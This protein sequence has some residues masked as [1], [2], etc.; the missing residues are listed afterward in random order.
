MSSMH[1]LESLSLADV[2]SVR[3]LLKGHSVIDWQRLAFRTHEEVE[4]FLRVNEMDLQRPA[5]REHLERVRTEAVDYLTRYLEYRIPAD[6]AEELPVEQLFLLASTRERHA[7]YACVVLKVMHVIH[8]L[9]GRDTLF[10]LPISDDQVFGLVENKVMQMVEEIRAAG[11]PIVEF[12][13]S[14]KEWDSIVTKLLAKRESI[15]ARVYD[16]LRFRL[17]V[18]HKNDVLPL[19]QTLLHRFVPF[20]YVIPGQTV[21]SLLS[22]PQV[23]DQHPEVAK[24]LPALQPDP[25]GE[26]NES[27]NSFSAPGY[28]VL[29]FIADIPVRV[30]ALQPHLD[31][32]TTAEETAIVFVLTEFQ[33]V[34]Q[35]TQRDNEQQENSHRAYKERQLAQVRERLTRGT[36]AKQ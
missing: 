8:H 23:V 2:E 13:W 28:K 34:D 7:T 18:P 26:A 5:D 31:L 17:V 4:R 10:R 27:S 19:L 29:N 15:A 12:S 9:E 25:D 36:T 11:Y 30:S 6:I 21:H 33:L 3:L 32:A 20:N 14:R 35:H 24:W 1:P 16:K 22:F